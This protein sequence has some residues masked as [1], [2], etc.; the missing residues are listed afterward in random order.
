M[1]KFQTNDNNRVTTYLH[2]FRLKMENV[3]MLVFNN[4]KTYLQLN[5][6]FKNYTTL[7]YHYIVVQYILT[8]ESNKSRNVHF[9]IKLRY[10]IVNI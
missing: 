8:L 10:I 1:H 5:I 9:Y 7:L 6:N 4:L 3:F 2:A